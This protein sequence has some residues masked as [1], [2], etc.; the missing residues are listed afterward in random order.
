MRKFKP[1]VDLGNYLI[2]KEGK[3]YSLLDPF[4]HRKQGV[5]YYINEHT[6]KGN[7]NLGT[8]NYI[9]SGSK[10]LNKVNLINPRVIKG[11]SKTVLDIREGVLL[12]CSNK[13]TLY[14][15]LGEFK[16]INSNK[17]VV[18]KINKEEGYYSIKLYLED[19]KIHLKVKESKV[20]V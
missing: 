3:S 2:K 7:L 18:G 4:N 5:F 8:K 11:S 14:S 13:Y 16:V 10:G 15:D 12:Y 20:I 1:T 9:I 6:I 17:D 19:S